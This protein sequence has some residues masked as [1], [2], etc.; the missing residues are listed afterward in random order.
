MNSIDHIQPG[1]M[2]APKKKIN[3]FYQGFVK[4]NEKFEFWK[5][6]TL[7]LNGRI[8]GVKRT[9]E[10]PPPA[11]PRPDERRGGDQGMATT[12]RVLVAVAVLVAAGHGL[13]Q[14][15]MT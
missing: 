15:R 3:L 4:S 9:N 12:I 7:A 11:A 8:S 1:T 6:F 14:Q 10:P 5:K 2:E 13:A